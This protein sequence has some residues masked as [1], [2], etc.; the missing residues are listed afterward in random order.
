[1]QYRYLLTLVL[2]EV[3]SHSPLL[4]LK[5]LKHVGVPL[6]EL[7][8]GKSFFVHLE[9]GEGG[10]DQGTCEDEEQSLGHFVYG[11]VGV[12]ELRNILLLE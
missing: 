9:L 10:D 12:E 3:L 11:W 8:V 4:G 1:M 6:H 2:P 7:D 5:V